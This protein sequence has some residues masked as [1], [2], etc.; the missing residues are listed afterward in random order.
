MG[1]EKFSLAEKLGIATGVL[2]VLDM[3]CLLGE[4]L[5]SQPKTSLHGCFVAGIVFLSAAAFLTLLSASLSVDCSSR[6]G[7][8]SL[9]TST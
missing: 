6:Q 4:G 3:G 9:S 5:T 1:Q 2:M 8:T 7:Y